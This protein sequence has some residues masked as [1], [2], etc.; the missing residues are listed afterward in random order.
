MTGSFTLMR[1][2]LPAW[3]ERRLIMV[4]TGAERPYVAAEWRDAI[5]VLEKGSIVLEHADGRR[6]RL[7]EGAV[8]SLSRMALAAIRNDGRSE[9]IIALG[10]RRAAS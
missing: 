1:R 3:L 8:F 10:R 5:A 2:D 9:A 7:D 4:G 6:L